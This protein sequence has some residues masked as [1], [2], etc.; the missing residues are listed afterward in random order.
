MPKK[1]K[2]AIEQ[3]GTTSDGG[4]NLSGDEEARQDAEPPLIRR[5]LMLT[6]P[7]SEQGDLHPPDSPGISTAA[8]STS[9]VVREERHFT[10]AL[11]SN[12]QP[13]LQEQFDRAFFERRFEDLPDIEEA[14]RAEHG[15]MQQQ[16][17]LAIKERR[18]LEAAR[19]QDVI[20]QLDEEQ[21]PAI[22]SPVQEQMP[23]Q[24]KRELQFSTTSATA[25]D[26]AHE[27]NTAHLLHAYDPPNMVISADIVPA[28]SMMLEA[29]EAPV[30]AQPVNVVQDDPDNMG[31]EET[32]GCDY[33][34]LDKMSNAADKLKAQ[35]PDTDA[36]GGWKNFG[37]LPAW[38]DGAGAGDTW[39]PGPPTPF[40]SS[41]ASYTLLHVISSQNAPL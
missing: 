26:M 9:R 3:E 39:D 25:F 6:M 36:R 17:D 37:Q 16:L 4:E 13:S 10:P 34:K 41:K 7:A 2:K 5:D 31:Q 27:I 21:S 38:G 30:A 33:D 11:Q 28:V 35:F 20:S 14:M 18:W 23:Q 15:G 40:T 19:L 8:F 32:I 1:A 29:T 12:I 24:I 22:S